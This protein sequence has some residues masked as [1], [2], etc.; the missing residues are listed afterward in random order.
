MKVPWRNFKASLE[1]KNKQREGGKKGKQ[2]QPCDYNTTSK[3]KVNFTACYVTLTVKASYSSRVLG[4]SKFQ[5]PDI[6]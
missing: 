6:P 3:F 2:S 1:F 5:L 4:K